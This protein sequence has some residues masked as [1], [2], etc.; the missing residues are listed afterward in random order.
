MLWC[1][2]TISIICLILCIAT[3]RDDVTRNQKPNFWVS[4]WTKGYR[5]NKASRALDHSS[6]PNN[7]T[8]NHCDMLRLI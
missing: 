4:I 2:I 6:L 5:K 8:I 3:R 7:V 1:N